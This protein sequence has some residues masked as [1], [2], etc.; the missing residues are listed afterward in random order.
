MTIVDLRPEDGA[1]VAAVAEMTVEGFAHIPGFCMT[2]DEA[3]V[4]VRESFAAGR[5]SR[6]A[7]DDA[8]QP[9]GWV[10]GIEAYHGHACELHPLVV[11]TS[12][13]GRGVGRALV[14]DFEAEAV[15]R[16][17]IVAYLGTDD[18]FG[19]TSLFGRDLYPDVLGNAA[20]IR[21]VKG[22]P[23]EFYRKCGF[24]VVGVL[25]D[26]NGFGMP[27]IIMAKR[28]RPWPEAKDGPTAAG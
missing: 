22:H 27:D 23:F 20:A 25:P 18:E 21:S 19:G 26:A 10:G 4:E 24:A 15:R 12:A 8:G 6:V 14:A 13:R 11:R 16:G 17:A 3:M 1:L 9:L 2:V 28:L 5:F 7:L